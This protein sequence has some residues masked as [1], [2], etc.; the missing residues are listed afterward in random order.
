VLHSKLTEMPL[1]EHKVERN[2]WETVDALIWTVSKPFK[3]LSSGHSLDFRVYDFFKFG[4][5]L[6]VV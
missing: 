3:I 4:R 6:V 5:R 2:G 1:S